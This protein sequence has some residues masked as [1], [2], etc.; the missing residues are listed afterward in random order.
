MTSLTKRQKEMG[1]LV[2]SILLFLALVA[3]GYF[4]VFQPA[5]AAHQT[6]VDTLANEREVLYA[7]Q[8]QMSAEAEVTQG[9]SLAIQRQ[10]PVLPLEDALLLQIHQAEIKTSTTVQSI[11]FQKEAVILEPPNEDV[12]E[13]QKIVTEVQLE[14]TRYRDVQAFIAEIEQ[15][16]RILQ[17]TSIQFVAPP[18][19]IVKDA[20]TKSLQLTVAF[21]AFFRPDLV[22]LKDEAPKVDAPP[23]AHKSDPTVFNPM[24]GN[25]P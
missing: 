12:S 21:D 4:T 11:Q 8:K 6:A 16:E 2:L 18:E 17:V 19:E 9:S 25:E 7:L 5:R 10:V 22:N 23:A 1:L 3:Y 15:M 13:L 14:A 20:T 24:T